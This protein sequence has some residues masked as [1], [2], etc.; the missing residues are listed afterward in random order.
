MLRYSAGEGN[1]HMQPQNSCQV[2]GC[3][4]AENRNISCICLYNASWPFLVDLLNDHSPVRRVFHCCHLEAK[5][6]SRHRASRSITKKQHSTEG[7]VRETFHQS[8]RSCFFF[9]VL[10]C[11]IKGA[12]PPPSAHSVDQSERTFLLSI[13]TV[14]STK[15]RE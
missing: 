2:S 7:K 9:V 14:K 15:S 6:R 4:E 8:T 12:L 5:L 11:K 10:L 13:D 3:R 1:L